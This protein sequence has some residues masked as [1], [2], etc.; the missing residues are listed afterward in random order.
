MAI[1][2]VHFRCGLASEPEESGSAGATP[3]RRCSRAEALASALGDDVRQ[4][5]VPGGRQGRGAGCVA[6][7]VRACFRKTNPGFGGFGGLRIRGIFAFG[8]DKI[9]FMF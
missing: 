3:A 4:A 2:I 1:E 8:D 5:R 6:G 7:G 9:S